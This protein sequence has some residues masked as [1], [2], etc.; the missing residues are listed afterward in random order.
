MEISLNVFV[1]HMSPAALVQRSYGFS[2]FAAL[3]DSSR[4]NENVAWGFWIPGIII[5]VT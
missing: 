2:P 5:L 3:W 1:V 4:G